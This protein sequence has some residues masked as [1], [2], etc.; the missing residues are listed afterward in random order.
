MSGDK[1]GIYHMPWSNMTQYT[2][3]LDESNEFLR[4]IGQS[5]SRESMCVYDLRLSKKA[6]D[7]AY[8][9][10]T[11]KYTHRLRNCMQYNTPYVID[12]SYRN[13]TKYKDEM[14][15]KLVSLLAWGQ[16]HD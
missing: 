1:P 7:L 3:L 10:L 9:V 5:Y 4:P 6:S 11:G 14:Q 2:R 8:N 15:Q 16:M 12:M 13:T